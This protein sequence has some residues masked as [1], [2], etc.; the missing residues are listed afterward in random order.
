MIILLG[1]LVVIFIQTILVQKLPHNFL[2][3]GI[4]ISR[5][6]INESAHY[7]TEGNLLELHR[8]IILHKDALDDINYIFLLDARGNVMAHTFRETLPDELKKANI[9]EPGVTQ[10]IKSIVFEKEKVLDIASVREG[11]PGI[12][13]VGI[14][15]KNIGKTI[16]DIVLLIVGIL[17]GVLVLGG[18]IAIV[19]AAKVS[20]PLFILTKTA[21][22]VGRGDLEHKVPV[23][24]NDEIG[25]LSETFNKMTGDLKSAKEELMKLNTALE[26]S[27][28]E[29]TIT[30]ERLLLERNRA[31]DYLDIV[32]VMIVVIDSDQNVS[33][34]NKYGAK[35]LGD[36]ADEIIGQNWFD[37]FIPE[38]MQSEVK[39]VFEKLMT[40][41]SESL[42]YY[43][44]PV[45]TRSGEEKLIA[46][47]NAVLKDDSGNIVGTLSS[48]ED[49][50]E[51]RKIEDIIAKA[52]TEWERTF[53]NAD[54]FII[55]VDKDF[56]IIRCNKGFTNLIGKPIKTIP[57][58]KYTV[59]FPAGAG[60]VELCR[61]HTQTA[62]I[63]K[64]EIKT[65][66]GQWLYASCH[67]V[68]DEK[69]EFQHAII[70]L[71]DITELKKAQ[72]VLTTSQK[73]LE[74]KVDELERFYE[75]AVDREIK[76]KEL[77][78]EIAKL[79]INSHDKD[80]KS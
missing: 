49:I 21:E 32:G 60:L 37:N 30:K 18:G 5:D 11:V 80:S 52:K 36:E 23:S 66:T 62:P 65:E 43:E 76:M 1:V 55:L 48:G 31:Q 2:Q 46:W 56:T 14:S 59:I 34:I 45:L 22:M 67:P 70:M 13:H 50:T 33:L 47:H 64:L 69:N 63:S 27:N 7:I 15:E 4:S 9:P 38:R 40:G 35:L 79:R 68:F 28:I 6:I 72:Q 29:L 75:V 73:E 26:T 44:N 24:T 78:Q 3:A 42:E 12:L 10:S 77:K 25:T 17:A 61:Q 51:H 54:E 19:F 8:G 57:G 20:K 71:T 53:D 58:N 41:K 16:S 39:T 74:K